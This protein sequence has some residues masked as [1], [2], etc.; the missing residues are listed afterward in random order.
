[1]NHLSIKYVFSIITVII[2]SLCCVFMSIMFQPFLA[3][4]PNMHSRGNVFQCCCFCTYPH[5]ILIGSQKKKM[6]HIYNWVAEY[7]SSWLSCHRAHLEH[8]HSPRTTRPSTHIH[9][10]Q[11][12]AR[13][14]KLHNRFN[15]QFNVHNFFHYRN[16]YVCVCESVWQ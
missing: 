5:N 16:C 7:A 13:H 8:P 12:C 9:F 15:V 3:E 1:M 4:K 14:P 6:P 2:I 11:N 10:G